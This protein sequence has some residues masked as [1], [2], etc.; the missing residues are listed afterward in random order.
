[1]EEVCAEVWAEVLDVPGVGAHD[2]FF[3]LGGDSV[4]ATRIVT[5]LREIFESER[6]TLRTM[7]LSPTVA[8]LAEAMV[9]AEPAPGRTEA[10]AGIHLR[11]SRMS[12]EEVER[13]LSARRAVANGA[14]ANGGAGA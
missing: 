3:D 8:E 10:V 14:V 13:E 7:F 12:P 11:I 6:I 9:A 2:N 4:L 1:M 5:R